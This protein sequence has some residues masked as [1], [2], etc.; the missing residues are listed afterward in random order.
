M[1]VSSSLFRTGFRQHFSVDIRV[2]TSQAMAAIPYVD[3]DSVQ[4]NLDRVRTYYELL[5]MPFE[6]SQRNNS[7][8]VFRFS[9]HSYILRRLPDF[10]CRR[11]L[12]SQRN[13]T[14]CLHPQS[15][16]PQILIPYNLKLI[17]RNTRLRLTRFLLG[18][19]VFQPSKGECSWKRY[20]FR[21]SSPPFRNSFSLISKLFEPFAEYHEQKKLL[22]QPICFI[23]FISCRKNHNGD[24]LKERQYTKNVYHLRFSSEDNSPVPLFF[25]FVFFFFLLVQFREYLVLWC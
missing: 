23:I 21:C 7:W 8:F 25:S 13:M 18:L 4:Q 10:F 14:K 16:F 5:N 9:Q 15:L 3:G 11:Y 24:I 2:Y 22:Q 12:H 17:E 20:S 6:V 19:Q 1:W